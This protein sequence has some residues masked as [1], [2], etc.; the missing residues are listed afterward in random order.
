MQNNNPPPIITIELK[1]QDATRLLWLAQNEAATGKV[2]DEYWA[3]LA[4][5]IQQAIEEDSPTN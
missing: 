5:I 4:A 3:Q 2:W 1:A